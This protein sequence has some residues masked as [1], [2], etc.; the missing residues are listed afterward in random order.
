MHRFLVVI[1]QAENNYLAYSTGLTMLVL[2]LVRHAQALNV[3]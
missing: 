1:E 3:I 2:R